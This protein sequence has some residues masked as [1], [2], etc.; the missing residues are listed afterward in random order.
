[1]AHRLTLNGHPTISEVF[2]PEFNIISNISNETSNTLPYVF[3]N[4][5]EIE[6]NNTVVLSWT[7]QL[8]LIR[9][10]YTYKTKD[11]MGVIH[12]LN[13]PDIQIAVDLNDTSSIEEHYAKL[14]SVLS[15][16]VWFRP[17]HTNL[18]L[19][20]KVTFNY[21]LQLNKLYNYPLRMN[22]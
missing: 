8:G 14:L 10:N 4:T 6:G 3:K 19:T 15:G 16:Y 5:R 12:Y 2:I 11:H 1:M 18:V 22:N 9:I 13:S 21:N 20:S 7:N 17:D